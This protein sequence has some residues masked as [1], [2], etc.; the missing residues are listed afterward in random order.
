MQFLFDL[1]GGFEV[2]LSQGNL[3]ICIAA[4]AIGVVAAVL[5]GISPAA[6]IALVLPVTFGLPPLMGIVAMA[7]AAIGVLYGRGLASLDFAGFGP[8]EAGSRHFSSLTAIAL[9]SFVGGVVGAIVVAALLPP[10]SSL[11]LLLGPSE[12]AA[13]MVFVLIVGAALA[14]GPIIRSVAVIVLGLLLG[15]VGSDVE[16]GAGRL[17]FGY[18]ELANGVGVETLALGVFVV[19]DVVRGLAIADA[20]RAGAGS[21]MS[22]SSFGIWRGI[23]LGFLAGVLPTR[24]ASLTFAA[25]DRAENNAFDP[26]DPVGRRSVDEIAGAAVASNARLSASFLPL[27]SLGIP[28]NAVAAL[29]VA[30]FMTHGIVPGP[31]VMSRQPELFWGLLAS[32]IIA[33][34][35]LLA[36]IPALGRSMTALGRISYRSLAPVILSYCCFAAYS[37]NN[38]PIDVLL[39]IVFGALGYSLTRFDFERG[40]LFIAFVMEPFLEENIRRSM[41]IMRGDLTMA[42]S[43]PIVIALIGAAVMVVLAAVLWN[44]KPTAQ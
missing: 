31:Q 40:L 14:P 20:D 15:V 32:I 18:A 35:G 25:N 38:S 41:L 33:Y 11:V 39:V 26:L 34:L 43:R 36:V 44:R 12:Y 7:A 5:P 4:A 27:L 10:V 17:T 1:A 42:L 23:L 28:T 2:A 13:L 3:I 16:T 9:A 8:G 22:V 21:T 6:T 29:L 24:S 19:A 37:V 30:G